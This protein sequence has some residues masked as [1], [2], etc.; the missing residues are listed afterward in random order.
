MQTPNP[1]RRALPFLS[2]LAW[3]PLAL[4][5]G[6]SRDNPVAGVGPQNTFVVLSALPV[7]GD[8]VRLDDPVRFF[9]SEPVDAATASLASVQLTAFDASGTATGE[10]VS[11]TF[12]IADGEPNELWFVPRL[13]E[14]GDY[15]PTTKPAAT[16]TTA[17]SRSCT[18]SPIRRCRRG[19]RRTG[20]ASSNGTS[21][22]TSRTTPASGRRSHCA[23]MPRARA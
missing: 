1:P 3:P 20:R 17:S 9:C 16:P 4:F 10:V 21:R 18:T 5:A 15:T 13:T 19:S 22:S 7:S 12:R 6:R 11:G 23:P 14:N 2:L 8:E